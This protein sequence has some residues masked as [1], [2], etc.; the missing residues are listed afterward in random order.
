[1]KQEAALQFELLPLD[2]DLAGPFNFSEV[3]LRRVGRDPDSEIVL[4]DPSV[5]RRHA[6][7]QFE[8]G[9]WLLI[10]A[11]SRHGTFL[12][13]QQ[14]ETEKPVE[15]DH[16]D[17]LASPPHEYRVRI[18]G[19]SATAKASIIAL[20]ERG[21]DAGQVEQISHRELNSLAA[22][23]LG[24]LMDRAG[25]IS[26]ARDQAELV[27]C[28]LEILL[29]GTGFGRAAILRP[30][31]EDGRA[32]V[33]GCMG[34]SAAIRPFSSTLIAAARRGET[35]RLSSE[36]DLSQAV[37]IVAGG[38]QSAICTP[39]RA[40]ASIAC[41][42]YLDATDSSA[43]AV[44]D[45]AY[46][47]AIA[48]LHGLAL[49][50]LQR[51]ELERRQEGLLQEIQA[52]RSVQERIMPSPTGEVA[53]IR[54]AMH[55]QPGRVVAGDLFG[56][57]EISEGRT[58]FF[59]GD[60]AG[61]GA[62]AG[63]LM[64]VIQ[65]SLAAYFSS[66]A[67][68][69]PAID[70]LNE[71]VSRHTASN[72]FSTLFLAVIDTKEESLCTVD[73][74]HGEALLLRNTK[75]SVIE[76]EGGPPVGAVEGIPFG[77]SQH[78]IQAGDRILLYSDGVAEEPDDSGTQFGVERTQTAPESSSSVSEDVDRV[79]EALRTFAGG[80]AFSDDV[81]VASLEIVELG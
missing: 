53:G 55:A 42:I 56:F 15:I 34:Q 61:K 60:V 68:P 38:V 6:R 2:P 19:H 79:M 45:A 50:N 22:K 78:R 11:G 32:E 7:I 21:D 67:A 31:D 43:D 52:A 75:S 74:G 4:P 40:G 63:M 70:R 44:D 81:T 23:R 64:A 57:T 26:E 24:L 29:D 8:S 47:A 10:D 46:C 20:D 28:V 76:S 72:E 62:A 1:M 14:L 13:G 25:A 49:G 30:I 73:A 27:E 12:N 18:G 69:S 33:I 65:A 5:S 51:Q 58:A 59:L 39:V 41:L 48:R 35:V 71:F 3:S 77:E 54:Y 16:G 36:Q 66:G 80:D 37:S 17:R 9:R